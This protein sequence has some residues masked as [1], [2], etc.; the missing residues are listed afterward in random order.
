MTPRSSTRPTRSCE[1]T[2]RRSAAPICTSSKA[3]RVPFAD[4]SVYKVPARLTDEQ[5]LFLADILPTSF[6]V[7]VLNGMVGPGDVVAIVGAGPIGLAAIL[8]ARLYT[9]G[10]IVAIDLADSRLESAR[11]FGADTTINNGTEDPV[12][13]VMDA[14]GLQRRLPGRRERAGRGRRLTGGGAGALTSA[15][16]RQ[17]RSSPRCSVGRSLAQ[18]SASVGHPPGMPRDWD[19]G[20]DAIIPARFQ[21][22]QCCGAARS[23]RA[24][25]ASAHGDR[26]LRAASGGPRRG[27]SGHP[28]RA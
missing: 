7:G 11:R 25:A 26:R 22:R 8:T 3:T 5:V 9:P 6:E 27:A 1:S 21:A 18:R 23:A 28:P 20:V 2:P 24:L 14:A 15:A 4:N 12:A 16:C 19:A 10:T 13:R 17:F